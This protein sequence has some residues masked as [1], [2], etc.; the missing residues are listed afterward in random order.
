[1]KKIE[2]QWLEKRRVQSRSPEDY[3][4]RIGSPD[5]IFYKEI[6]PKYNILNTLKTSRGNFFMLR[7]VVQESSRNLPLNQLSP[8]QGSKR[9][10]MF[11]YY[12][13]RKD[14]DNFLIKHK[15]IEQIILI[16]KD[17]C[18]HLEISEDQMKLTNRLR[19]ELLEVTDI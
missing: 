10:D 16:N 14:G 13:K 19:Q 7:S 4:M 2:E 3:M 8:D 5:D 9:N 11:T 15:K 17:K 1:M 6:N 12:Q 18:K